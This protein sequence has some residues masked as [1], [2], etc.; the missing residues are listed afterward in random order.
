MFEWLT[1]LFGANDAAEN[2]PKNLQKQNDTSSFLTPNDRYSGGGLTVRS[3]SFNGEKTPGELGAPINLVPDHIA[4]RLRAHEQDLNSD[5]VKIITGKFFKW[6][7]GSGLKIQ[8]EPSESVLSFEGVKIDAASFVDNVESYFGLWADSTS[9]DYKGMQSLNR[10][11]AD[12]YKTAFLGGDCLVICRLTE[13]ENI[14]VQ[15]I[16]GQHVATPLFNNDFLKESEERGNTIKHGIELNKQGK[17]IAF[18]VLKD[19][20]TGLPDYERVE[21]YGA[22]SGLLMAWMVYGTK[23]RIDHHRGIPQITAIL[24]KVA[25]LDRYTEASVS[26]A[27][28]RAKVPWYIK[29]SRFSDGENPMLARVRGNAGKTNEASPYDMGETLANKITKTENKMVWNLPIDSDFKAIDSNA[30]NNYD[31]FFRAVFVQLCAAVD[32]PPEVALQQYNSNYSASRAAINGWEHIIKI[33][34]NNFASDFYQKIY[35]NFLYVH[36][37]TGRVEAP[38]YLI[39][40]KN[41]NNYVVDAYAKARFTGVN[42]PHIDPKK[43]ADALR[44]MLGDK[45]KGELPLITHEQATER[46]GNGE[47]YENV[48]KFKEELKE[49]PDATITKTEE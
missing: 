33:H 10:L 31:S 44:I 45:N 38:Q 49:F 6:V 35:S 22:K 9:A 11:A 4:L 12:A 37:L 18:Y 39:A 7:V 30:E 27:E 19:N 32:I 15:V 29:H 43:E 41:K 23:H 47:Y 8:S 13:S 20:A 25:K 34:R 3:Y 42:M 28:E 48:K 2:M 21:A 36:I 14:S 40:V 24:E 26:S 16:D 17:H 46:L 1:G 5:V